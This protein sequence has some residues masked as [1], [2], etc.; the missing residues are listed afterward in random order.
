MVV[1]KTKIF[2]LCMLC[3]IGAKSY[4]VAPEV[5][6]S[7]V[8]SRIVKRLTL[9]NVNLFAALNQLA[10]LERIPIGIELMGHHLSHSSPIL[11]LDV[12]NMKLEDVLDK[13]VRQDPSYRWEWNDGVVRFIPLQD[14]DPILVKALEVKI[15]S[16]NPKRGMSPLKLRNA[17]TETPEV[18]SFMKLHNI[19]ALNFGDPA[20]ASPFDAEI[21]LRCSNTDLRGVLNRIVK[22]STSKVWVVGWDADDKQFIYIDF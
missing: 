12:T 17:I 1:K 15:A 20:Q 14:R 16:F 13:L 10:R 6:G 3:F 11:N 4:A 2:V 19:S 7:V 21:D 18:S 9:T 5:Q 22:V 8:E